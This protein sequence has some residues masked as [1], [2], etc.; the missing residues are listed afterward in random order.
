MKTRIAHG[1]VH[2]KCSIK[3][4]LFSPSNKAIA[5]ITGMDER[6]IS[7][8]IRRAAKNIDNISLKWYSVPHEN[9]LGNRKS[10]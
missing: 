4:M 2:W 10:E 8:I 6:Q 1:N 5:Q 7:Y 3:E 9:I